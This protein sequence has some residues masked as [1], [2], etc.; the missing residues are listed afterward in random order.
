[1][2]PLH[3]LA[4]LEPIPIQHVRGTRAETKGLP[5]PRPSARRQLIRTAVT[6]ADASGNSTVNQ[7][8]VSFNVAVAEVTLTP[9]PGAHK[10]IDACSA[11]IRMR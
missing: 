3:K 2:K 9:P 4:R 7:F 6:A 10:P 11:S 8:R 5:Y 1:M